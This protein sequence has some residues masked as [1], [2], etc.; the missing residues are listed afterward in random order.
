ML[1]NRRLRRKE[2]MSRGRR[3]AEHLRVID[4]GRVELE[5]RVLR[6]VALGLAEAEELVR[7]LD[8]SANGCLR[9]VPRSKDFGSGTDD[10]KTDG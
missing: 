9:V 7:R 10:A 6:A 4:G 3:N 8:R 1:F 2:L 5:R